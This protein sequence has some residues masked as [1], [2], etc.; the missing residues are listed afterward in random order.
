MVKCWFFLVYLFPGLPFLSNG[1]LFFVFSPLVLLLV[2]PLFPS[3]SVNFSCSHMLC[4]S[5]FFPVLG[6]VLG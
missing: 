5:L 3:L 2:R 4:L 6:S 1:F